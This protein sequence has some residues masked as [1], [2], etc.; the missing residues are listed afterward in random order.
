MVYFPDGI[1]RFIRTIGWPNTKEMFF[2]ARRYKADQLKTM[3]LVNHLAPREMLESV[4]YGLAGEI[5]QNAPL[6]LKGIKR[7]MNLIA[8]SE[9][10]D[11]A[12]LE[13]AR[14]LIEGALAS[15]DLKEGRR[16]FW[17]AKAGVQGTLERSISLAEQAE[18]QRHNFTTETLRNTELF[19]FKEMYLCAFVSRVQRVVK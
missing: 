9:S 19:S 3:G 11:A 16:L 10:L 1:Q 12:A 17:K 8:S 6:S 15:R 14:H 4:T 5:A 2:T 13:E 18:L 7:I